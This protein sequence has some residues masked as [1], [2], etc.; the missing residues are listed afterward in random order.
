MHRSKPLSIGWMMLAGAWLL[1]AQ[2]DNRPTITRGVA[3]E[4]KLNSPVPLDLVFR[5]EANQAV[6]LRMYF[7]EKPVVMALVYYKCP[8]L[9]SL[10]LTEMVRAL[11]RLS[12]EPGRDYEVVV[13]SFDPSETPQLA[14]EKKS[15]Y[16]KLFG[17]ASFNSGWHF[18]TGTQDSISRFASAVG[19]Q[20]RWD[21]PTHQFVHAGGIMIATPDGKLSR[22]FYGIRYAPAD[23]RLAL[24]EASQ[25]KIGS[26]VDDFL[27]YCFHYDAVQ[28]KYSLV[29]FNVLKIVAAITVLALGALLFFLMR[30]DKKPKPGVRWEEAHHVR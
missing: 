18:L 1:A 10:T 13:V 14:S 2:Q 21:E 26:P 7:G 17:R 20:Y 29:I 23:L 4:Q 11:H 5:D 19:F 24:V 16:A 3:I 30:R 28:G 15:N 6:P 25:G 8:N 9:C 12:F 22:Y 27:L